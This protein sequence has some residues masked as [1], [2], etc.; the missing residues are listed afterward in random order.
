M[1]SP[2]IAPVPIAAGPWRAIRHILSHWL[3]PI[4]LAWVLTGA[5]HHWIYPADVRNAEPTDNSYGK[6]RMTVRLPGTHAGV[7]EPLLTCGKMGNAA[8]V[9]IRLLPDNRARIGVEF[10]NVGLYQG[11]EFELSSADAEIEI[12]CY[13]PMLFPKVDDPEWAFMPKELRQIRRSQ[14]LVTVDRVVRLQGEVNYSN[15]PH[16]P[17]YLGL[18]PLGGSFVTDRFTGVVLRSEQ[19][20]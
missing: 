4:L 11:P 20:F 2:S 8:L 14:Y 3:L 7:P 15:D 17:L 13:L 10:W 16:P 9:Y 19:I 18:N 6:V 5:L 1:T 12:T